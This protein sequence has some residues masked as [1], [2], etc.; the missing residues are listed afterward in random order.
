MSGTRFDELKATNQ[1]PSPSSVALKLLRLAELEEITAPEVAGVLQADPALVGR[2]LKLANS[3]AL[4]CTRPVSSIREAV[5]I[6]GVRKVRN[7][8]LSFSLISQRSQWVCREFDYPAF[9]SRSLAMGVAA[10]AVGTYLKKI[11]PSDAFT[12]GLLAQVGR[13]ALAS[14]YA[15]VY[16]QILQQ[17][18][19]GCPGDLCAQERQHFATDHNELSGALMMDWGLPQAYAA[20]VQHHEQPDAVDLPADNQ[21]QTLTQLLYLAGQMARICVASEDR[22]REHTLPLLASGAVLGIPPADLMDLCDQAVAEWREWGQILF[23]QTGPVPPFA[24]LANGAENPPQASRGVSES[25]RLVVDKALVGS[26][27][28]IVMIDDDLGE[29]DRVTRHL[30]VVG[31][32][33]HQT[34]KPEGGIQLVLEVSPQ[35]VLLGESRPRANSLKMCKALRQTKMGRM[36]FII[37]LIDSGDAPSQAEAFQAGADDCLVR[38]LC[39][40]VLEARLQAGRRLLT[41]QEELRHDKEELRRVIV[42][43]VRPIASF[44]R[45]PSPMP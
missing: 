42:E 41:L 1:L 27:L 26:P 35:V 10:Q 36:L 4:G 12:C 16:G 44:R 14:I 3:S 9:W 6:L 8:A 37:L 18:E 40:Q 43:L 31:H 45:R 23:V 34:H 15:D 30:I 17:T 2:T 11:T 38:P 20:A 25:A 24:E 28:S 39:P 32:T 5:I 22:R 7:L 19:E 13:L 33:L 21:I 29:L